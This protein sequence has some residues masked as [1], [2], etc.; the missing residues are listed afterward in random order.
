MNT[1]LS[2]SRLVRQHDYLALLEVLPSIY[3]AVDLAAFPAAV[4]RGIRRMIPLV[5]ATYNEIESGS[6]AARVVYEPAEACQIGERYKPLFWKWR[7]QHPLMARYE[8]GE[9]D[10]IRCLSDELSPDELHRLD[11]YREVLAPLATEDTMSFVVEAVE[12]SMIFFALNSATRFTSRDRALVATLQPHIAQGYRNAMANTGVRGLALLA[13]QV[14]ENVATHGI[15]L[16]LGDGRIVHADQPALRHLTAA[17]GIKKLERLPEA[18]VGWLR[19]TAKMPVG[20]R[21]PF[22]LRAEE[23]A[24]V[25]RASPAEEGHHLIVIRESGSAAATRR[26]LEAF[27]ITPREADV[28]YWMNQGKTNP[29]IGLILATSSRTIDKHV[30]NLFAKIGVENRKEAIIRGLQV[31]GGF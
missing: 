12:G 28:F 5:S 31:I 10:G 2:D 24:F 20:Q 11:L 9:F 4:L 7:E 18:A 1:A 30:Q 3:S 17:L 6:G 16:A 19:R 27:P 13:G 21:L 29:E 23:R 8:R 14:V 15:I 22:E 25:L 26:L